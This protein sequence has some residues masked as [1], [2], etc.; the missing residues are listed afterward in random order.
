MTLKAIAGQDYEDV[1]VFQ[2]DNGDIYVAMRDND[3]PEPV[4]LVGNSDMFTYGCNSISTGELTHPLPTL[5]T[6]R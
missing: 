6:T 2:T 1:C 3:S 5:L 4:E